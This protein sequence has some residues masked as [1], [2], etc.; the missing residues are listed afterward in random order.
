MGWKKGCREARRSVCVID[1]QPERIHYGAV[2]GE[3]G[4]RS[5]RLYVRRAVRWLAGQGDG[6]RAWAGDG[7]LARA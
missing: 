1:R 3:C 4:R 2:E 5:E 7:V 6:S